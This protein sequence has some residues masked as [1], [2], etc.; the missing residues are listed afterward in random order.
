M[1]VRASMDAENSIK[2]LRNQFSSRKSHSIFD[3]QALK[4]ITFGFTLLK[5][6]GLSTDTLCSSISGEN[7]WCEQSQLT[8]HLRG[9]KTEIA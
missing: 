3:S 6:S 2:N 8:P 7:W 5:K 4:A 1:G 9:Y